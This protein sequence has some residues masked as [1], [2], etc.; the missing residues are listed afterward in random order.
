MF[1]ITLFSLN[2][3]FGFYEGAPQSTS[4]RCLFN[5]FETI[6]FGYAQLI[7]RETKCSQ[8]RFLSLSQVSRIFLTII[9]P[10]LT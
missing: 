9:L 4:I 3:W 2:P 6:S 10:F 5:G 7:H 1:E 8:N